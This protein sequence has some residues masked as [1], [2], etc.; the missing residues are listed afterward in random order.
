M[1]RSGKNCLTYVEI[2][3]MNLQDLLEVTVWYK[4]GL[5]SAIQIVIFSDALF[6]QDLWLDIRIYHKCEGRIEKSV[7]GIAVWH[8]EAC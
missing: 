3:C 2:N 8:H 6:I 7:Q 5:K 4:T 1:A